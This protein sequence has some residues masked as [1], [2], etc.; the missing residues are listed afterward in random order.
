MGKISL[1]IFIMCSMVVALKAES[2]QEP[3][4]NESN[5]T[6]VFLRPETSSFWNTAPGSS[7]IL[8]ID[9]PYGATGASLS[10][11][12][13]GYSRTYENVPEGDFKLELPA[14]TTPKEENIYELVLTF[15][16]GVTRTARLG[17]IEGARADAKG[18][19]RCIASKD[20]SKWGKI[21]KRAV[22]PI[23][24]G[25][26]TFTIVKSDGTVKEDSTGLNGAQGWYLLKVSDSDR[27]TLSLTTASESYT[28]TIL[29]IGD[30]FRVIVK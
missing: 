24:Y 9:Y 14:A 8:P 23:P 7:I 28:Q 15:N 19:T 20:D 6:F 17:L 29:G 12:G 26:E 13:L 11:S 4:L 5:K 18:Y 22:L 27:L 2:L 30:G 1:S 3:S 21:K 25:V 10:V 16:N